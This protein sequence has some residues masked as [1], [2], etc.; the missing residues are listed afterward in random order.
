MAESKSS[1]KTL[2]KYLGFTFGVAYAVQIGVWLI[3][4]S[5]GAGNNPVL[6]SIAQLILAAM[7]FVPLLGVIVSGAGIKDIGWID[8]FN[9]A[10]AINPQISIVVPQVFE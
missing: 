6:S 7:M 5:E 4:K 10:P 2:F 8:I 9:I 1:N 3:S